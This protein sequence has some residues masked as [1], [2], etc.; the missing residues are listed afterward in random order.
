MQKM[1]CRNKKINKKQVLVEGKKWH[2]VQTH[3]HSFQRHKKAIVVVL[4]KVRS[5]FEVYKQTKT[6][7]CEM[8][9]KTSV[10]LNN[11]SIY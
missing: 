9:Y 2:A 11:T 4:F 3:E 1:Q 10:P 8:Q 5:H 7:L 6:Y